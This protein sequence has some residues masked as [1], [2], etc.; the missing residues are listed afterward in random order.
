M[1]STTGFEKRGD[2]LPIAP[3]PAYCDSA[4][5]QCDWMCAYSKCDVEG[6]NLRAEHSTGP[7]EG[8]F[9]CGQVGRQT[10]E[11]F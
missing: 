6:G 11:R 9:G 1:T 8:R 5:A 4:S 7:F 2:S 10:F 3:H